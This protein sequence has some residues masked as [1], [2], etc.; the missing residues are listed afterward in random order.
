MKAA[1]VRFP[2]E[3][4][5]NGEVSGH[6]S[7]HEDEFLKKGDLVAA[8]HEMVDRKA[9]NVL[10]QAREL[11]RTA[12]WNDMT[13]LFYPLESKAPEV[14]GS[15]WEAS[16]RGNLAFALTQLEQFDEAIV[17]LSWCV[18][19][20]PDNF[21]F[22]SS[23]GYATYGSLYAAK[24]RKIFLHGSMKKERIAL[25][26]KHM[27]ISRT[28]KPE[29]I[30]NVYRYGML[31]AEIEGKKDKA[32]PHFLEAVGI[33]E[34]KSSEQMEEMKHDRKYYVKALYHAAGCLYDQ[35]NLSKALNLAERYLGEDKDS[36]YVA[37]V[38]KHF[39]KGKI[40][41]A[42]LQHKE[43]DA[44]L[45]RSFSMRGDDPA[46]YVLE[47][48]ARNLLAAGDAANALAVVRRIPGNKKKPYCRW[49][50]GDILCALERYDEARKV[51]IENMERD[52]RSRHKSLIRLVKIEYL[53]QRY[54][55]S[56]KRAAEARQFF[57]EAWGKPYADGLYWGALACFR[58]GDRQNAVSLFKELESHYTWY[59]GIDRLRQLVMDETA[60]K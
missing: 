13:A 4:G 10:A 57:L 6:V 21:R 32:L 7:V 54:P 52:K 55:E 53:H 18:N 2:Q 29:G 46:E 42:M 35:G 36:G 58:A 23:L 3:S 31:M 19:K 22:H 34:S 48:K 27:E 17:E 12:S 38:F 56:A 37:P 11:F 28:L 44:E 26:A 33:W 25:A 43:A 59:H 9:Q 47:L 45:D 50:E 30:A 40:L 16:V 15:P 8:Q 5:S 49:T 14:S 41:F 60:L 20:E 24:N 39:L 51:L 1:V